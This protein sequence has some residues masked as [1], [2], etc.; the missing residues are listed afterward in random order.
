MGC[1]VPVISSNAGGIPEINI[2]GVTGFLTDVGDVEAMAKFSLELLTNDVKL[3][4]FK[5]NALDQAQ[6]FN[7]NTIV[8]VY[9]KLY[10]QVLDDFKTTQNNQ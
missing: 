4:Q 9:E 7:I 10:Q 8:P 3:N 2:H 5:Q 6:K 1:K